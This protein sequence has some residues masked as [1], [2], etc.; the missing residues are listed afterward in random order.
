MQKHYTIIVTGK[1]QGVWYR[2]NTR[3]KALELGIQGFVK[4]QIDGSVYIEGEGEENL[5]NMFLTW[6]N[7]GPEFAEVSDV[8]CKEDTLVFYKGFEIL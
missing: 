5:L 6:C 3:K 7:E 2:K 1:V 4:N 8:S